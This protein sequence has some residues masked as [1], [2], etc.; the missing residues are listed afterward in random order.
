MLIA[1]TLIGVTL[2]S[3]AV[4]YFRPKLTR[5]ATIV[6]DVTLCF[7]CKYSLVAHDIG[8]RVGN[9]TATGYQMKLRKPNVSRTVLLP[10]P[11]Q[12]VTKGYRVRYGS[13]GYP[14]VSYLKH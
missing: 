13:F 12:Y 4:A 5:I 11:Y 7:A 9:D 2:V 1:L 8:S 10:V 3:I 14:V 6:T